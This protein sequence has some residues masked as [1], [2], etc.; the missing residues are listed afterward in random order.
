MA[1]KPQKVEL[2][3]E[4]PKILNAIRDSASPEYQNLVPVADDTIYSLREIGGVIMTYQPF[5]TSF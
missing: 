4:S 2:T 5:A 3:A 1:R